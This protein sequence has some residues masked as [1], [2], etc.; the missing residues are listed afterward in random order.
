[1]RQFIALA[2]VLFG[3]IMPGAAQNSASVAGV[4]TDPSGAVVPNVVVTLFARDNSLRFTTRTNR[5]GEYQF[6]S[7]APGEYLMEVE[8]RHFA[9]AA[10]E[11]VRVQRGR[12]SVLDIR[13]KLARVRTKVV[14]TSSSTARTVEESLQGARTR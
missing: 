2:L 6:A 7:V 9:P 11:S 12:T 13:I 3:C 1:M 10:A 14:V 5:R 4:I 8:A